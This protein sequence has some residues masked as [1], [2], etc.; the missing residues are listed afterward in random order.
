ELRVRLVGEAELT[1]AACR[2]QTGVES[3][4]DGRL[5]DGE[6][7]VI[8][9]LRPAHDRLEGEISFRE[10]TFVGPHPD[11]GRFAEDGKGGD[12]PG[13]GEALTGGQVPEELRGLPARAVLRRQ[14]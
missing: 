10:G 8:G 2:E 7:M 13:N 5:G 3:L 1:G 14:A 12:P 9:R 11:G 6:G 4:L